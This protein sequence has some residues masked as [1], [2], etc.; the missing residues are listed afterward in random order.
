MLFGF[1]AYLDRLAAL[2]EEFAALQKRAVRLAQPTQVSET[3]DEMFKTRLLP[4]G[5]LPDSLAFATVVQE[6]LRKTGMSI[7][8]SHVV[9]PTPTSSWVEFQ[10]EGTMEAWFRFVKGLRTRDPKTLFR[11]LSAARKEGARYS[12]VFEVGHA[13]LP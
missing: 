2:D 6:E 13:I 12:L 11:S 4:A 3:P 8:G 9:V 10:A 7:S 5:P 1:G